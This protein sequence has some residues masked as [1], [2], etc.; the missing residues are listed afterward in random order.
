MGQRGS[1]LRRCLG[2]IHEA[3]DVFGPPRF[4]PAL[5]DVERTGDPGQQIVEIMRDAAGQLPHRLHLLAL[6]QLLLRELERRRLCLLVCHIARNA[7][8]QPLER[9]DRPA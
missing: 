4:E 9:H 8:K 6:A 2:R 3:G 7:I 1:P 5:Y